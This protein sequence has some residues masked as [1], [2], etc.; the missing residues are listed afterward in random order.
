M[1]AQ[2]DNFQEQFLK[3]VET[4]VSITSEV[5]DQ[6]NGMG[7]IR[8]DFFLHT[9]VPR[10][11]VRNFL[12]APIRPPTA[13]LGISTPFHDDIFGV[14]FVSEEPFLRSLFLA[15]VLL[16]LPRNAEWD[17]LL[18]RLPDA[19]ALTFRRLTHRDSACLAML[20]NHTFDGMV[21]GI[22]YSFIPF[23]RRVAKKAGIRV[24]DPLAN[25][26]PKY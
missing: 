13:P 4:S 17:F 1:T 18:P 8:G 5:E 7:N 11:P 6:A 2:V 16:R 15:T 10:E 25:A 19:R 22:P 12:N 26:H 14:N 20:M 3:A 9:A 21:G 23:L 24:T